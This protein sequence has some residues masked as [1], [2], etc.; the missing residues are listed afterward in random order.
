MFLETE[1]MIPAPRL[2]EET[3]RFISFPPDL[4]TSTVFSLAT[5]GESKATQ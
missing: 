5:Q 3:D 4:A 2:E 1:R